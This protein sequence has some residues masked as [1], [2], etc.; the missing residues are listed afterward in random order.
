MKN[1]ISATDAPV[2]PARPVETV[3]VTMDLPT[4]LALS[5]IAEFIG[6]QPTGSRGKLQKLSEDVRAFLMQRGYDAFPAVS[7]AIRF[8]AD[9]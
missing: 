7:G 9:E 5:S 2:Q 1:K 4:A 8:A 6:G 3:T